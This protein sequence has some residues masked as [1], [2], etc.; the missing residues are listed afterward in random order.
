MEFCHIIDTTGRHV[1]LGQTCAADFLLILANLQNGSWRRIKIINRN[2]NRR[3]LVVEIKTW[4]FL[5]CVNVSEN[6]EA[7]PLNGVGS[8]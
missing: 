2:I 1:V 7:F 6:L 3:M 5:A 4:L 8:A